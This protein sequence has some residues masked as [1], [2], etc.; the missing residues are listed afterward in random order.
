MTNSNAFTKRENQRKYYSTPDIPGREW[1]A[2]D[3]TTQ[4][5]AVERPNSAFTLIDPKN[6][7]KYPVNPNRVWLLRKT[8]SLNILMRTELSFQVTIIFENIKAANDDILE[9]KMRLKQSKKQGV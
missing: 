1:R 9:M 5:T 6:G 7:N 8:H 3:L 2:H 4:R